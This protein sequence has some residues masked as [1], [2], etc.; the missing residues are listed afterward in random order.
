MFPKPEPNAPVKGIDCNII[1]GTQGFPDFSQPFNESYVQQLIIKQDCVL[2]FHFKHLGCVNSLHSIYCL[3]N[4]VVVTVAPAIVSTI[5]KHKS[6]FIFFIVF[7]CELVC[8][9]VLHGVKI[10]VLT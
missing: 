4:D 5:H 6:N 1:A 8:D 3:L 10:H 9:D 2:L 7:E